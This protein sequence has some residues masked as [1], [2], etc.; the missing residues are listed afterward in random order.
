MPFSRPPLGNLDDCLI[1]FAFRFR[2]GWK[3]LPL[4]DERNAFYQ[5]IAHRRFAAPR[6]EVS[7][8]EIQNRHFKRWR[9]F[10][11][12]WRLVAS[13]GPL[14]TAVHLPCLYQVLAFRHN[15]FGIFLFKQYKY[16][17]IS[18]L[19]GLHLGGEPKKRV[20]ATSWLRQDESRHTLTFVGGRANGVSERDV[21]ALGAPG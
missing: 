3:S 16:L 20:T 19:H 1:A 2:H 11:G 5:K 21:L 7:P 14:S 18:K 8:L 12:A 10:E 13:S 15:Y 9:F 4:E 6:L 17:I